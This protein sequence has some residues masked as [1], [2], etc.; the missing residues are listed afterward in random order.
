MPRLSIPNKVELG[1]LNEGE[2]KFVKHL[3][4]DPL[5]RP[6]QAAR[7]AGYKNPE[8][9]AGQLMRRPHVLKALG[10]NN[11]RRFERLELEADAVLDF[12]AR[13]I[14]FNPLRFFE[15]DEE[16]WSIKDPKSVPEEI[17]MLVEFGKKYTKTIYHEDGSV[18]TEERVEVKLPSK[19]AMLGM[20]LKHLGIDGTSKVQHSGNVEVL[21]GLSSGL[22]E[23]VERVEKTRSSQVID[24]TVI[25]DQSDE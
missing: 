22:N 1:R 19:T 9:S 2:M 11:R 23:L 21:H 10:R 25:E 16:G 6:C 5:W 3:L 12:L 4:A 24:G 15:M 13:G 17:G 7:L 18:E 8:A 14:F 20:A